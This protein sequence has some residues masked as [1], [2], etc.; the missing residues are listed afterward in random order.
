M[1]KLD[2]SIV[3]PAHNEGK[4][5]PGVLRGL[6]EALNQANIKSE[7][8]VVDNGSIDNTPAVLQSLKKEINELRTLRIE[9]VGAGIGTIK[10]LEA[11]QG[12]ILGFMDADGQVRPEDI[13]KVFLKLKDDNLDLCKGTRM[14][15][16]FSLQ[17]KILSKVYNFLFRLMF[18]SPF[19]DINGS[20]KFFTRRF[21]EAIKP[22]SKDWFLD[23]EIMLKAQKGKYAV[24]EVPIVYLERKGGG[25]NVSILTVFEFLKNMFYWFLFKR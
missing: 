17:R 7:I 11:A 20:P 16:F 23:A 8:I 3:L 5:L 15:R 4:N 24:G 1:E 19:K 10:G 13:I 21:Y 25:S 9:E 12:P 6:K 18:R 2:L 22:V 14:G